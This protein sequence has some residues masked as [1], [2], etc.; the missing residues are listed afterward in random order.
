MKHSKS[1]IILLICGILAPLIYVGSD[2][3]AGMSWE[4]YSFL[5][6]AVSELRGIGAPTRQFL[7]PILF[8]YALLEIAFGIGIVKAAES[9]RLLRVIGG[10]LI[11]LGLLDVTGPMF[12]MNASEA[13]GSITNTIHI[14]A[15]ALTVLFILLIVILGIFINGKWF[16]IYSI[17]TL[18][19]VIGG[20]ALTFMQIPR[21]AANLPTP[22]LGLTE[23]VNIYSY[24]L[25]LAVLAIVLWRE[26]RR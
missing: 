14:A 19:I 13:V 2:I 18:L 21:I 3:L 25:W 20:S 22:W 9:K 17:F 5:S 1:V 15:T 24:M 4:G 10:M 26:Q 7:M 6:R 16:R 12:A 8:I 11:G 23:R